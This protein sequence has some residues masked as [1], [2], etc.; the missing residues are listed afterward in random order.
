MRTH[1]YD[2]KIM[3]KS[4]YRGFTGETLVLHHRKKWIREKL[5]EGCGTSMQSGCS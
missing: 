1:P 5:L 3:G 2:W 4:L